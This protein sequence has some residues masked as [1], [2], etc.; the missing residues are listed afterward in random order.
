MEDIYA[1]RF[2]LTCHPGVFQRG[3]HSQQ[4]PELGLDVGTSKELSCDHAQRLIISICN[5][6]CTVLQ[7]RHVL[8]H[9]GI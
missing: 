6:Y 5:E 3:A 2:G 7:G 9:W 4:L 1:P 8:M